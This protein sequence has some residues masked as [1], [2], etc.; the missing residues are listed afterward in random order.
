MIY[1]LL[2]SEFSLVSLFFVLQERFCENFI[3]C[4]QSGMPITI[5]KVQSTAIFT[6]AVCFTY[7]T[8]NYGH[9]SWNYIHSVFTVKNQLAEKSGTYS[10]YNNLEI[11]FKSIVYFT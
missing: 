3:I 7:Q 4:N 6:H 11:S 10:L 8:V 5:K 9:Y 1:K 2:S